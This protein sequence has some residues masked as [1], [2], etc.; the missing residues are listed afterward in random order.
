MHWLT[1]LQDRKYHEVYAESREIPSSSYTDRAL[2]EI[3]S[4]V[5]EPINATSDLLFPTAGLAITRLDG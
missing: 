5:E 1:L 4:P 3:I 2:H